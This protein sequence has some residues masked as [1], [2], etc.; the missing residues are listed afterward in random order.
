MINGDHIQ[1]K[2]NYPQGILTMIKIARIFV[3]LYTKLTRTVEPSDQI[4]VERP[5]DFD[6]SGSLSHLDLS[7][8][9]S[10]NICIIGRS[11]L[12]KTTL[13]KLLID[14][15]LLNQRTVYVISGG[16]REYDSYQDK[17]SLQQ[18]HPSMTIC[19]TIGQNYDSYL[20]NYVYKLLQDIEPAKNALIVVDEVD[21]WTKKL[22]IIKNFIEKIQPATAQVIGVSQNYRLEE[23]FLKLF[24]V[25]LVPET[26]LMKRQYWAKDFFLRMDQ[27]SIL[28][29]KAKPFSPLFPIFQIRHLKTATDEPS[30]EQT[31]GCTSSVK[32]QMHKPKSLQLSG[33][34]FEKGAVPFGWDV[35]EPNHTTAAVP[36]QAEDAKELMSMFTSNAF[37][38]LKQDLTH[39]QSLEPEVDAHDYVSESDLGL[40]NDK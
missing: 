15:A 36:R 30:L 21:P 28:E 8:L 38:A 7:E 25:L 26:S 9:Q 17:I 33:Q 14:K 19:E 2:I 35:I 10:Q 37:E 22:D 12:R 16:N 11:G 5:L 39:L 4:T 23:E 32:G 31:V 1:S 18:Y 34:N 40:L 29:K 27:I 6:L 3:K 13:C 24:P 20:D